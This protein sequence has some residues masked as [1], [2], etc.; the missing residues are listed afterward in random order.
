VERSHFV[1]EWHFMRSRGSAC[2]TR[3]SP[4]D[5]VGVWRLA[6]LWL[7]LLVLGIGF[8]TPESAHAQSSSDSTA[9][10][11]WNAPG[12]DGQI[13]RAARYELRYRTAAVSNTD[14]LS[15]WNAATAV[16]GLPTPSA[17]GA[18]DSVVVRGLD[19]QQS[20]FFIVRA[21]DEVFNWSGFSNLAIRSRVSDITPPAAITDLA[22]TA[23]GGGSLPEGKAV[24]R[25]LPGPDEPNSTP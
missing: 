25:T 1:K 3:L 24:R 4:F 8:G 17:A 5:G 22:A 10:L 23:S 14:T 2:R 9:T 7:V 18:L 6:G 21:A 13:G 20:Y 11:L 19:P 15:W 12:D 16:S